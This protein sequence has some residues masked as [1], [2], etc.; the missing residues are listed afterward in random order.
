MPVSSCFKKELKW[1]SPFC[2]P[3]G[4]KFFFFFFYLR[5]IH[6][7]VIIG[8]ILVLERWQS[9]G[10]F[11]DEIQYQADWI[12]DSNT[13]YCY[14]ASYC[15]S[16]G[17]GGGGGG[18]TAGHDFLL[19]VDRSIQVAERDSA[20][21]VSWNDQSHRLVDVYAGRLR[22]MEVNRPLPVLGKKTRVTGRWSKS[23]VEWG[24]PTPWSTW[25]RHSRRWPSTVERFLAPFRHSL[26]HFEFR[27][28][29]R[30]PVYATVD[31]LTPIEWVPAERLEKLELVLGWKLSPVVFYR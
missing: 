7:P 1:K 3:F 23:P 8:F 2:L 19:F 17:G 5:I 16:E 20:P 25:P 13:W 30:S 6:H 29:K 15:G 28:R 4:D 18:G 9:Y 24:K 27:A 26:E 21:D 22:L 12:W 31:W 11:S 14:D 10:A